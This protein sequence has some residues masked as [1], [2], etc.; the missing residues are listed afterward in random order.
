M[1]IVWNGTGKN[2]KKY[3]KFIKISKQRGYIIEL[4]GIWVPLNVAK[5]RVRK[6]RDSYGRVVP[7]QIITTSALNVP[8]SFKKLRLEADLEIYEEHL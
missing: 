4:N 2:M 1:N 3:L 6:R 7:D 5:E 8:T